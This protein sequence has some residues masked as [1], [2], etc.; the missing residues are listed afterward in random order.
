MK[1]TSQRVEYVCASGMM[2]RLVWE[3]ESIYDEQCIDWI[4]SCQEVTLSEFEKKSLGFHS[5]SSL[6]QHYLMFSHNNSFS[7][8]RDSSRSVPVPLLLEYGPTGQLQLCQLLSSETS[9]SFC[10]FPKLRVKL[11]QHQ[12]P[13]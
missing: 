12:S 1:D 5:N 10:C 4:F 11:P 2:N 7:N 13:I 9:G 8:F 6:L 3:E